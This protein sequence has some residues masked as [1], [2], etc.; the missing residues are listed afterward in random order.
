MVDSHKHSC[1]TRHYCG[2]MIHYPLPVS[3]TSMSSEVSDCRGCRGCAQGRGAG[4]LTI[5]WEQGRW[6]ERVTSFQVLGATGGEL[7]ICHSTDHREGSSQS[8][9]QQWQE[10]R[11]YLDPNP[12]LKG[13]A[14]QAKL[15][16]KVGSVIGPQTLVSSCP[17]VLPEWSGRGDGSCSRGG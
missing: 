14:D 16:Q 7:N 8:A 15:L 13:L 10:M 12:Q 4:Y 1:C 17:M 3:L 6:K 11:Q 2:V 5:S 9:T